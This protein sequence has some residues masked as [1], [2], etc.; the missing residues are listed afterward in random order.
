MC[1]FNGLYILSFSMV[2]IQINIVKT[3]LCKLICYVYRPG[4]VIAWAMPAYM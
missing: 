3:L 2:C 4:M 1:F